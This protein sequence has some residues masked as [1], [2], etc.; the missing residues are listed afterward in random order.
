MFEPKDG[1]KE[2][3]MKIVDN[4]KLRRGEVAIKAAKRIPSRRDPDRA[5]PRLV[6]VT[7]ANENMKKAV[8]EN[9]KVLKRVKGW[10]TT[11]ITPDLTKK[12]R[13][14]AYQLCVEKRNRTQA[15]EADLIIR[16]GEIVKKTAHYQK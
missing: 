12:Q 8:L 2:R 11:Y 7:V 14:K 9:A 4:L 16:N 13:E 1:P 15:G 10:E 5:L 6:L 3:V